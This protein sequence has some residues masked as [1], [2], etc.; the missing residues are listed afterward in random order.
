[1]AAG[2]DPDLVA[3]QVLDAVRD[4]RFWVF[5]HPE[6][7][8]AYHQRFDGIVHGRAPAVGFGGRGPAD[9]PTAVDPSTADHP[10]ARP[11]GSAP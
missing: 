10:S 8:A 7:A 2:R 1:V 3:E 5:T 9:P 6:Y 11:T 4:G